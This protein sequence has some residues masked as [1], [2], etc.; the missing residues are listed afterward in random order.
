MPLFAIT[1]GFILLF[2]AL[3][4]WDLEPLGT[5]V[6]A[7]CAFSATYF[8]LYWQLLVLATFLIGLA[9]CFFPGASERLG[10]MDEPEFTTFQ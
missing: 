7:S 3:A 4:L 1:G 6:N 8:G 2:C 10:E 5:I 9:L